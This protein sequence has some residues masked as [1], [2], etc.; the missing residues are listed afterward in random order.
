MR[1]VRAALSAAAI[2]AAAPSC[3]QG[4]AAGAPDELTPD[5][6]Q[7]GE[8]DAP[9]RI[10]E[11]ASTTCGHC[12]NFHTTLFEHVKQ[13]WI[14]TGQAHL[15][16]RVLPTDPVEL[17]VTGSLLARCAGQDR[18]FD[19]LADLFATQNELI[20][21]AQT[22]AA[23]AYY[24]GVG[25]RH[26]VGAGQLRACLADEAGIAQI[27]A[28]I[29]A[30]RASGVTGTPTFIINGEQHGFVGDLDTAAEWDA[31]MEAALARG[32]QE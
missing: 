7:M 14:D 4:D 13:N 10:V 23:P 32:P 6:A 8:A 11:Y 29:E 28:S 3:S 18:Y 9:I 30:A 12:A 25:A 27:N 19:V 16:M 2:L 24:E 1:L 17:S 20:E 21:S 26:G 5:A 31:A 22:G 15:T